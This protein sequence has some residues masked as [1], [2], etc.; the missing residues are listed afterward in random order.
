MNTCFGVINPK[1][2]LALKQISNDLNRIGI[3]LVP[4]RLLRIWAPKLG[5]CLPT[6]QTSTQSRT[7]SPSLRPAYANMPHEQLM[8]YEM[9]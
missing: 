6:A 8:T 9:P 2:A 3:S 1:Q 4:E 5:S 7:P